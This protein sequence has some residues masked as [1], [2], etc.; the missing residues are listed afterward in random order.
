MLA[1]L[2]ITISSLAFYVVLLVA[3]DRD[4]RKRRAALG[5]IRKINLGT[6]AELGAVPT[7]GT[8][9]FSAPRRNSTAVSVHFAKTTRRKTLK[10]QAN[11]GEP[12]EV[13]S[14]RKLAH[15]K[16]DFQCG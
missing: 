9:A 2:I 11:V 12:A 4:R 8:A 10:S 13:I 15:G 16:D 14:L 6:V 7:L 3:L 5:P 1:F